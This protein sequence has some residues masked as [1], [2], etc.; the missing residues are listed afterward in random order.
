MTRIGIGAALIAVSLFSVTAAKA[1]SDIMMVRVSDLNTS[2]P[3]G[4]EIALRRIK[5]A[6]TLFC[7]DSDNIT[8]SRRF[9]QHACEK[10][11]TDKAVGALHAPTVTALYEGRPM[12]LASRTAH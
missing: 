2:S 10:R 3:Q 4:A 6:S 9:E 1:Q 12:Q 7:G 8:L 5:N 11:M